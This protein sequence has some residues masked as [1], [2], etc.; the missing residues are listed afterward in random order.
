[1][2]IQ[3]HPDYF[4]AQ[5]TDAYNGD[6]RHVTVLMYLTN[7][8]EGGETIFPNGK[9][10]TDE[11]R[12]K[13]EATQAHGYTNSLGEKVSIC[14]SRDN[15]GIY[16]KP[17]AGDAVMF[18]GLT[19]DNLEDIHSLHASCPVLAGTKWSATI[20]MH[21]NPFRMAVYADQ[22]AAYLQDLQDDVEDIVLSKGL[23]DGMAC[24]DHSEQ[25]RD[26]VLAGD[27]LMH[28]DLRQLACCASCSLALSLGSEVSDTRLRDAL[29]KNTAAQ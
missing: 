25:C 4:D 20:W 28:P 24:E 22:Q 21:V 3:R 23:V 16:V 9:W 17:S 15:T 13:Y 27:C 1:M 29:D 2:C 5:Y 12:R 19:P 11:L 26:W 8:T 18:Y 7:V 6:Q 10:A 14:A